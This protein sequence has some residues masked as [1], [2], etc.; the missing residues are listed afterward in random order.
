VP[1]CFSSL[2]H[3]FNTTH[4]THEQA[5]LHSQSHSRQYKPPK[6]T[7]AA[8]LAQVV[9]GPEWSDVV[10]AVADEE[11]GEAEGQVRHVHAHKVLLT[12]RSDYFK[13]IFGSSFAEGEQRT[14]RPTR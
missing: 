2:I 4:D 11:E 9:D 1:C 3:L 12:S 8:E 7:F 5:Q 6:S 14:L 13:R 10:F